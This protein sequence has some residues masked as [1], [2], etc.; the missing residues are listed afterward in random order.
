VRIN[1]EANV[2]KADVDADNGIIHYID[3]VIV[4]D[5]LGE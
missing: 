1:Y 4:G 2:I 5:L 3:T